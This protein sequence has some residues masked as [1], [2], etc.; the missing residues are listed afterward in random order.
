MENSSS[1]AFVYGLLLGAI[2]GG[3]V[4]L[5]LR[6][7]EDSLEDLDDLVLLLVR[8]LIKLFFYILLG[9]FDDITNDLEP[10]G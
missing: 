5:G 9:R 8:E 10:K 3:A 6:P 1:G 7:A 4:D 2:L